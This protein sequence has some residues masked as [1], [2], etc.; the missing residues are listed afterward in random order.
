MYV[1]LIYQCMQWVMGRG[2]VYKAVVPQRIGQRAPSLRYTLRL[3]IVVSDKENA[4]HS[5][6]IFDSISDE[7]AG[8]SAMR[9]R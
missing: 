8:I 7:L 5:G 3:L 4:S 2:G 9:S 6:R 1:L